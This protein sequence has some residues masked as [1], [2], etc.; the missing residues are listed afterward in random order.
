M[1]LAQVVDNPLFNHAHLGDNR[2]I[3]LDGLRRL[4][5]QV[6]MIYV[7]LLH[8]GDCNDWDPTCMLSEYCVG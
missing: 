1:N 8:I 6:D 3:S 4:L 7:E 2:N 5:R